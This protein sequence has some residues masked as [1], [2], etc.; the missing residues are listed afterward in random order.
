M[1]YFNKELGASGLFTQRA[2]SAVAKNTAIT[3]ST[4]A[5]TVTNF[6]FTDVTSSRWFK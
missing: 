2:E 1:Y 6:F 5:I 4:E 3:G